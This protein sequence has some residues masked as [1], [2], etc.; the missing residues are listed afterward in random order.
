[1]QFKDMMVYSSLVSADVQTKAFEQFLKKIENNGPQTLLTLEAL[2]NNLG[3]SWV[4]NYGNPTSVAHRAADRLLQKARKAKIIVFT[5]GAW[6]I[7]M[8]QERT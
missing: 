6:H 8:D 2:L 1:M 7:H 4:R 5:K 3:V